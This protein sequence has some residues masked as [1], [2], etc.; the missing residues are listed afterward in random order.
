M[1]CCPMT[2]KVKGYPFEVAIAGSQPGVVLSDQVKSLD[3]RARQA[4]RKG[5]V[6]KDELA[7][8]RAKALA[9]IRGS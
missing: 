7:E 1:I 5:A 2:T 9:L 3:W 4:K 6:T 8:V